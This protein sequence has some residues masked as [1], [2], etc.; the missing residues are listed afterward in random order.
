MYKCA[1]S[2]RDGGRSIQPG[3]ARSP[4]GRRGP[5]VACASFAGHPSCSPWSP[6]DCRHRWGRRAGILRGRTLNG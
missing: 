3:N 4:G 1:V 2:I 6:Q 5:L